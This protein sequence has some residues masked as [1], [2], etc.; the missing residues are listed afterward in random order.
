MGMLSVV[1]TEVVEVG[2]HLEFSCLC[3]HG[4]GV[5]VCLE[6]KR[7]VLVPRNG[8]C[9]ARRR[10][11][12]GCSKPHCTKTRFDEEGDVANYMLERSAKFDSC[13]SAEH[14]GSVTPSRLMHKLTTNW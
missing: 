10:S 3:K 12:W 7:R 13:S 1:P 4:A 14:A 8:M 9:S 11:T 6:S 2:T 5:V